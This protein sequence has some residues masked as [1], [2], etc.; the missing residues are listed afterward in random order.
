MELLFSEENKIIPI[1]LSAI[2]LLL[3]M[4]VS[5]VLFFRFAR[6]KIIE[7]E[8]EKSAIKLASQ[9]KVL[10][11]TIETQERERKRIAQDLH[12]AISAKLNVVSLHINMLLDGSLTT[13][14]QQESLSNVLGVTTN[15]LES[16]RQIAHDLLPP[17]LEKFGLV[18]ALKELLAEFGA[19]KKVVAQHQINYLTTL[20]KAEELHVFRIVQELLNNSVRH[21]KATLMRLELQDAAGEMKLTYKDNGKGFLVKQA[22]NEGG[23]GL[24]NIKSRVAILNG[25]IQIKSSLNQGATFT[26]I[27]KHNSYE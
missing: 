6:K 10:Q 14:E 20:T 19:T 9:K 18:E 12:D 2:F 1:V 22:F 26:I 7:K 27:I 8:L 11:A 4:V 23:L 13:N 25:E 24:K 21:G 15:V 16:S 3:F 17:I 5:L